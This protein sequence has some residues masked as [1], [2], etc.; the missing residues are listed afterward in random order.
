MGATSIGAMGEPVV[1]SAS[2]AVNAASAP[3][4]TFD[5]EEDLGYEVLE[6][7]SDTDLVGADRDSPRHL[8]KFFSR[9]GFRYR[10]HL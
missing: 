1:P 9:N 10:M 5:E 2:A 3:A 6:P 8:G 4:P 7:D